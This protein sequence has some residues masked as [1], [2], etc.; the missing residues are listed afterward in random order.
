VPAEERTRI[1]ETTLPRK[2]ERTG[3]GLGPAIAKT[4]VEA[5]GGSI[6]VGSGPNG[7]ASVHFS[8]CP[9]FRRNHPKES[10]C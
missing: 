9:D 3:S 8:F 6:G 1:F 5:H 2:R 10:P 7:G 4:I